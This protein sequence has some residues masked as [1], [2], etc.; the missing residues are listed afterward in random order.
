MIYLLLFWEYKPI[1]RKTYVVN[2]YVRNTSSVR[3][4]RHC[5][6]GEKLILLSRNSP[7]QF[8]ESKLLPT[9][10]K[11][12]STVTCGNYK[13]KKKWRL[14][15][16]KIHLFF[17]WAKKDWDVMLLASSMKPSNVIILF[18]WCLVS[19]EHKFILHFVSF[20]LQVI[21]FV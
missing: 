12:N 18:S 7:C 11:M 5:F 15:Q 8:G 4:W 9:L 6:M 21:S 10:T 3:Q 19:L 1:N 13:K 20:I 14:I 2:T 16:L 17:F